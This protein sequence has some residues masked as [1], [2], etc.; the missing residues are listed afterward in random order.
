L[1][2]HRTIELKL[3]SLIECQ[4][5][6]DN[7]IQKTFK[8]YHFCLFFEIFSRFLPGILERDRWNICI[9]RG[10]KFL[11]YKRKSDFWTENRWQREGGCLGRSVSFDGPNVFRTGCFLSKRVR[12]VVGKGRIDARAADDTE[13]SFFLSFRI[14]KSY[15][16]HPPHRQYGNMPLNNSS[17]SIFKGLMKSI[18]PPHHPRPKINYPLSCRSGDRA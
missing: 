14:E 12:T 10:D 15:G 5:I 16:T 18:L 6:F 3:S 9:D 13:N 17:I 7:R 4:I 8:K 1:I 11:L 2:K